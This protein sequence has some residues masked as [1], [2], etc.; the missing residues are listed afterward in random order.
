MASALLARP[1]AER[2]GPPPKPLT[3]EEIADDLVQQLHGVMDDAGDAV[4][5]DDV[6]SAF[7]RRFGDDN[8]T[9]PK[10]GTP[11]DCSRSG[12]SQVST[13]SEKLSSG[14]PTGSDSYKNPVSQAKIAEPNPITVAWIEGTW[15]Q[16]NEFIDWL[17]DDAPAKVRE[18]LL[19]DDQ[20][21]VKPDP[22]DGLDLPDYLKR[23][24]P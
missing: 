13:S 17:Y 4:S 16:R 8:A 5:I 15:E 3:T 1:G 12:V 20:A 2:S 23:A 7:E 14:L 21:T 6:R 11:P 22:D 10:T 9:Q 24:A 19:D 18:W